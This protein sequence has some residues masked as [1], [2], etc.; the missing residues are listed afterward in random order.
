MAEAVVHPGAVPIVRA[1]FAAFTAECLGTALLV[2]TVIGSGIMAERLS[3]GNVAVALL[4]NT[5][6]TAAMLFVLI[7]IFGP[8]SGAHFNPAVT[9]VFYLR[10]ETGAIDALGFATLQIA[11][12]AFGAMLANLMFDLP[13][14]QISH[15]LR[16]G[17][18]QWLSEFVAT[19]SLVLAILGT[20]RANPRAVPLVVAL[21]VT[22]AYWFTASTSF[23]NPAVTLARMLSDSFAGIAPPSAPAFIV[24]QLAGAL[25][26][27][28]LAQRVFGWGAGR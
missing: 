2:A 23:A 21:V 10:H 4:A 28:G 17:P 8:V 16:A 27:L 9:L 6:A 25:V 26:A 3:G 22:A 1:R 18:S 12:G 7:T 20:L 24:A 15:H 11:G 14:V 5:I 13:L 19:F